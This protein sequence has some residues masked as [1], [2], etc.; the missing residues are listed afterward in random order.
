MNRLRDTR[1]QILPTTSDEELSAMARVYLNS[2]RIV[3]RHEFGRFEG[4]VLLILS[5]EGKPDG[6]N[7]AAEWAPYVSGEIEE[8]QIRCTHAEM[9]RPE[10][11][12]DAWHAMSTWL[13]L[14]DRGQIEA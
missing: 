13:K 8:F 11:L 14:E 4:D 10:N 3:E 7:P 1:D 12:A 9:M 2:G 6:V 5:T